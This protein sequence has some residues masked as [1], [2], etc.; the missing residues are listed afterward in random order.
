MS[1][2]KKFDAMWYRNEPARPDVGMSITTDEFGYQ[3]MD[4]ECPYCGA[5]P[6]GECIDM[7]RGCTQS[8]G[9]TGG[10]SWARPGRGVMKK[11]V[12]VERK[13]AAAEVTGDWSRVPD[14]AGK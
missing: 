2:G 1:E 11:T 7:R 8:Q 5:L 3:T 14:W 10:S 4:I 9:G 6:D 12:H 13:I